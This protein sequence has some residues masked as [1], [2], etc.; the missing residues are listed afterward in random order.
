MVGESCAVACISDSCNGNVATVIY[1]RPRFNWLGADNAIVFVDI[2][3]IYVYTAD[4]LV[5]YEQTA[6]IG[7]Y[8]GVIKLPGL[9]GLSVWHFTIPHWISLEGDL[10]IISVCPSNTIPQKQHVG[11]SSFF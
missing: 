8:V 1:C 5:V 2:S 10:K 4:V 6:L 9:P 3:L 7:F 11:I